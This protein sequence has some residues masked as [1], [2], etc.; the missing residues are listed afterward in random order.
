MGY[1]DEKRWK[2]NQ[3][4]LKKKQQILKNGGKVELPQ[5]SKRDN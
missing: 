1:E 3:E 2:E 4:K 5:Q